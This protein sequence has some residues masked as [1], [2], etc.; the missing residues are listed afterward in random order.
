MSLGPLV[1]I[2]RA[3]NSNFNGLGFSQDQLI[4]IKCK[5]TIS[6]NVT[7]SYTSSK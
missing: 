5:F 3:E 7:Q 6:L 1:K 2:L 4:S